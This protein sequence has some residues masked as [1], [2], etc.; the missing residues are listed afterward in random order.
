MLSYD[1]YSA[2]KSHGNYIPD[3]EKLDFNF[4][5]NK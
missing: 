3:L 4:K 1:M 5:T 2:N